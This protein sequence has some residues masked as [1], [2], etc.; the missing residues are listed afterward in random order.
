MRTFP[1]HAACLAILALAAFRCGGSE[2]LDPASRSH[3]LASAPGA[4]TLTMDADA[5]LVQGSFSP[6]TVTITNT[7]ADPIAF[8]LG[9]DFPGTTLT[10][11]PAACV[12]LG[13]GS[14]LFACPNLSLDAGAILGVQFKIRPGIAGSVSYGASVAGATFPSNSALDVENVAPAATDVQVTG[15]S[16]NGSPPLGSAFTYTFQVKNNGPFGTFGGVSFTDALPASLT[17]LDVSSDSG[18]CSGGATVSCDLGDLPVGRQTT[19]KI[20]VQAPLSPQTIADTA[21]IAIGQ[22]TD[23]QPANDSVTVTVTAK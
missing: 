5:P 6:Y 17:F 4:L 9:L 22:Q 2:R 7:T 19:I 14:P 12:G 3:A 10:G 21:S 8:G 13:G 11:L 23:R 1:F 20:R 16:S 15:S 18:T